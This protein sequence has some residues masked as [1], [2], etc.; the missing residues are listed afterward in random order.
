MIWKWILYISANLDNGDQSLV[1]D[2][3]SGDGEAASGISACDLIHCI[4][5]WC[6]GLVFICHRQIGHNHIHT[7]FWHL[8]VKLWKA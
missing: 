7:V 6:V 4:P 3:V 2:G 8:T 1:G 5:C